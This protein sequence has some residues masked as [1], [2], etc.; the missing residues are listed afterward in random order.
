MPGPGIARL[1]SV[2]TH[3]EPGDL[4]PHELAQ[5][6][7][8]RALL[9]ERRAEGGERLED[10]RV[11]GV[12]ASAGRRPDLALG[13]LA[14]RAQVGVDLVDRE[15]LDS[16]HDSVTL[17]WRGVYRRLRARAGAAS[18]RADRAL[19]PG[20]A[21]VDARQGVV[22]ACGRRR[23]LR[24]VAALEEIDEDVGDLFRAERAL[25]LVPLVEPVA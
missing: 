9:G 3:V 15:R 13:L 23:V 12:G 21:L 19:E 11:P 25:G 2:T 1:Q 4:Q 10:G 20:Q 22:A 7:I 14:Q 6:G 18:R 17:R 8:E 5:H 16:R 24:Q